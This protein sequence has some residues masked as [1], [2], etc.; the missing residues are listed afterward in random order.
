MTFCYI[1]IRSSHNVRSWS[2]HALSSVL[3]GGVSR[4][5]HWL[6]RGM[7]HL[8]KQ[9]AQQSHCVFLPN[10]HLIQRL[11]GISDYNWLRQAITQRENEGLRKTD[12]GGWGWGRR[13]NRRHGKPNFKNTAVCYQIA[14]YL[15]D[16]ENK[17][18][19]YRSITSPLLTQRVI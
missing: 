6:K 17:Y 15:V 1:P 2:F 10:I 16:T 18:Q 7:P 3:A 8:H 4:L 14:V 9:R 11:P 5:K 12:F 19:V 13:L